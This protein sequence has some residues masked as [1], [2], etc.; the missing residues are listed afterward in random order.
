MLITRPRCAYVIKERCA[1]DHTLSPS[2]H[3]CPLSEWWW[4]GADMGAASR[5]LMY[6]VTNIMGGGWGGMRD[7]GRQQERGIIHPCSIIHSAL[8]RF[9]GIG[10]VNEAPPS[11]HSPSTVWLATPNT[12][13]RV[14]KKVGSSYYPRPLPSLSITWAPPP[15]IFVH[16]VSIIFGGLSTFLICENKTSFDFSRQGYLP[17]LCY[18]KHFLHYQLLS[19]LLK[20][21]V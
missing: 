8:S 10:E 14:K 6:G 19:L 4:W 11:V 12:R 5:S 3:L 9:P 1:Q 2:F 18:V 21:F 16:Y 13:K 17:F 15:F 20:G 7:V